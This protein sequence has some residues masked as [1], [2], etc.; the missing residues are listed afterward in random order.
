M[1]GFGDQISLWH[2]ERI[3]NAK[4]QIPLRCRRWLS[5]HGGKKGQR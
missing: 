3:R 5:A 4:N 2:A 1:A